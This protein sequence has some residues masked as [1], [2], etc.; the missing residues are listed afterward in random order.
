M[1]CFI[2]YSRYNLLSQSDHT[3]REHVWKSVC[4]FIQAVVV[5]SGLSSAVCCL[6]LR[7]PANIYL[8]IFW[9][10]DGH[11]SSSMKQTLKNKHLGQVEQEDS[12]L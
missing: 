6:N 1:L 5:L 9:N 10:L 12:T 4:V 8:K 3:E 11:K 7:Y 2:E